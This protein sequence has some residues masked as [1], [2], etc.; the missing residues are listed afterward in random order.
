[1]ASIPKHHRVLFLF[2]LCLAMGCSANMKCNRKDWADAGTG[3]RAMKLWKH[4]NLSEEVKWPKPVSVTQ[5]TEGA[6]DECIASTIGVHYYFV[7]LTYQDKKPKAWTIFTDLA[8]ARKCKGGKCVCAEEGSKEKLDGDLKVCVQDSVKKG[9]ECI[10]NMECGSKSLCTYERNE[11]GEI[12]DLKRICGGS[13]VFRPS[14]L[15]LFLSALIPILF[16]K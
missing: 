11:C 14:M 5:C 10:H 16:F 4:L 1:M 15:F 13:G 7:N 3:Q 12:D 6:S 9:Q 2:T 8:R